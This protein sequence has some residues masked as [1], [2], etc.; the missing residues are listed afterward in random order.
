MADIFDMIEDWAG[1]PK[2]QSKKKAAPKKP[3]PKKK[4]GAAEK[5]PAPK[6]KPPP[7]SP[8][9]VLECGHPNYQHVPLTEEECNKKQLAA[10]RD[11]TRA[12]PHHTVLCTAETCR[13]CKVGFPHPDWAHQTEKYRKPVP[14]SLWRTEAKNAPGYMGF[15]GYCVDPKTG[16]YVGGWGNNCRY[17]KDGPWCAVH[18][19]KDKKS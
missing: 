5:A 2:S 19:P 17:S 11:P 4:A 10:L 3:P 14:K 15:G 1:Y 6:K 12:S 8:L 9:K 13:Y 18:Q 7:E 16:F